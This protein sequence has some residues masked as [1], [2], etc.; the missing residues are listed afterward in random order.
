MGPFWVFMGNLL[1]EFI[2]SIL[3][4]GSLLR[5]SSG[6]NGFEIWGGEFGNMCTPGCIE[7]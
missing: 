2:E 6:I 4:P 7:P 1:W 3:E 5:V